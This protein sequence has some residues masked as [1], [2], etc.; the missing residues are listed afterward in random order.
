MPPKA[1]SKEGEENAARQQA[2][3]V[4]EEDE[5]VESVEGGDLNSGKIKEKDKE[6]YAMFMKDTKHTFPWEMV[7][8]D[9]SEEEDEIEEGGPGNEGKRKREDE[10][11]EDRA[12]KKA[13]KEKKSNLWEGFGGDREFEL[14]GGLLY[15]AKLWDGKGF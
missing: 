8:S 10:G 3:R 7:H 13:K 4:P 6:L 1:L 11:E 15:D 12:L 2:A 9:E 14:K 5:I